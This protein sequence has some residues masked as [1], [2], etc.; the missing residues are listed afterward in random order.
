MLA[1][2]RD[3]FYHTHVGDSFSLIFITALKG[4]QFRFLFLN[5]VIGHLARVKR[6]VQTI[7]SVLCFIFFL[8]IQE[9]GGYIS[10]LYDFCLFGLMLYV[11][12]KQLRSCRDCQLSDPHC[13]WAS[14]PEAGYQYL[15]HL[16][17]PLTDNCSS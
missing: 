12:G 16:I 8:L 13:S 11:Y 10:I 14:L 4:T 6:T 3:C 1:N 5:I 17:S 9:V 2:F 15:A 7:E